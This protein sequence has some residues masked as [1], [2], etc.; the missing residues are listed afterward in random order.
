LYDLVKD[1]KY[2]SYKEIHENY[3]EKEKKKLEVL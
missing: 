1:K 2:V 3:V